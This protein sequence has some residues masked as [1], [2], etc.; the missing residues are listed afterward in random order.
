MAKS[1]K[2]ELNFANG[3]SPTVCLS[4]KS[5]LIR[6]EMVFAASGAQCNE[7]PDVGA[8]GSKEEVECKRQ[9]DWK[10]MA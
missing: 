9:E 8:I 7:R 4:K 6:L 2:I 5:P 1:W 3:P 10:L